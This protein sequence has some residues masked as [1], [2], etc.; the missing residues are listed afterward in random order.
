MKED[1]KIISLIKLK[2]EEGL[3]LLYKK[4]A[5]AINGIIIRIVKDARVSEE[6]LQKVFLKVWNKIDDYDEEKS[7][8][9]T[10]MRTIARNM[11]IDK[12]RLKSFNNN[13]KTE[14]IEDHVYKA[15]E[16]KI[17][18]SSIDVENILKNLDEKYKIVLTKVYLEGYTQNDISKE[19]DIPLGTVKTR[20]KKAISILRIYLKDEKHLM[21]ELILLLIISLTI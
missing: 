11:A 9:F 21:L 12:I 6:I 4:Y 5:S 10:W 18:F 17:H 19:L 7:Q 15:I 2:K 1:K 8:I 16:D 13:Q 3:S 20:I 14:D